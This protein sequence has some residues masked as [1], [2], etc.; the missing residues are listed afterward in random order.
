MT[1]ELLQFIWKYRFFDK[2]IYTI[3]NEPVEV[4]SAGLHNLNSGP[5]FFDARIRIAGT[6]WAGNVEMHLKTSDWHKHKHAADDA[7]R[8]VILH[9]VLEHDTPAPT[10]NNRTLPTVVLP[11]PESLKSGFEE[12]VHSKLK[13]PCFNKV[14]AVDSFTKNMLFERLMIERIETKTNRILEVLKRNANNFE[15]TFYRTVAAGFGFGTNAQAFEMLADSLPLTVLAKHKNDIFQ[16]E[17]L[18]FG[19]SGLLNQLEFEDEYALKLKKEYDFLQKKFS[20]K[21]LEKHVWKFSKLRPDNFPTIRIAQFAALI[22]KSSALFSK[23]R[24]KI[25]V[26][27]LGEL[28]ACEPSE[29]WHTH[30][31]F[32]KTSAFKLKK[33]GESSVN[34]VV[35]NAV[36]PTLYAFG[37]ITSTD[38]LKQHAL[39]LLEQIKAEKNSDTDLWKNLGF[40]MLHAGHSQAGIQLK[41]EY[42]AKGNCL[43][44]AIGLKLLSA[45][46]R[47]F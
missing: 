41:K 1:E 6:L 3:E 32:G 5:D 16:L 35:I 43:H 42:C 30:Y 29:Y 11:V 9:V 20:L 34:S 19:Q 47:K 31:T 17:A 25:S 46:L 18:L 33:L 36:I 2:T 45:S 37:T 44:C 40:N 38:Y 23:I 12:L 39:Q 14:A 22:H 26:E 15:E 8:N 27:E 4:I 10:V 28:F 24:E 13:I 21:P 7:Y